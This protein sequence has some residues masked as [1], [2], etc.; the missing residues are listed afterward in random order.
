M[1]LRDQS[2]LDT[3]VGSEGFDSLEAL[4]EQFIID[5]VCLGICVK[6]DCSFTCE[7]EPDQDRG[8]CEYCRTNTVKSALELAGII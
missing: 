2:K 4:L 8:W 1:M 3:L 6:P 7:V 5:S